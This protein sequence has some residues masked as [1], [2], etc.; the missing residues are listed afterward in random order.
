M[1]WR[2]VRRLSVRPSICLSVNFCAN[3]FFSQTYDRIAT[4]LAQD[5]LQVSVHPG[6][7]QGQ[8]QGQRSRDTRTFLHSWNELLC[9]WRMTVWLQIKEMYCLWAERQSRQLTANPILVLLCQATSQ[10]SLR[11]KCLEASCR[12]LLFTPI[13]PTFCRGT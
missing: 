5:G 1:Q 13:R 11:L 2:G 4:K 6:C 12:C 9:H 3:R 10:S 8:G 7:A